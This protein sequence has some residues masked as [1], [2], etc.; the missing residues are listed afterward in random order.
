LLLIAKYGHWRVLLTT[1]IVALIIAASLA[2]RNI[3]ATILTPWPLRLA[4]AMC[5]SL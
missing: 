5:Y 4:G 2:D 3:M 1:L